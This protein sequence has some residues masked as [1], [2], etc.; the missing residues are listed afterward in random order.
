AASLSLSLRNLPCP[1]VLTGSNQPPNENNINERDLI[2]SESDAWKNVLQSLQFIQT[3]GHRFTEVFVCFNDTV[4]VAV[5][6]R[7]DPIDR[8]PQRSEER[9]VGKE[10]R[11]R[12]GQGH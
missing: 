2:E 12:R 9:R 10:C 1:I 3:F 4:H 8:M 11:S 5:N 6:L 7:K